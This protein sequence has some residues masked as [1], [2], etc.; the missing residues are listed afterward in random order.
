MC[1]LLPPPQ[2]YQKEHQQSFATANPFLMSPQGY[3]FTGERRLGRSKPL[4][5]SESINP[6]RA[7]SLQPSA[8]PI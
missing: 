2:N 8:P 3:W 1:A 7:M 4:K 5:F 6:S